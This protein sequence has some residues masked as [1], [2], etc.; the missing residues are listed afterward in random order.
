MEA[1]EGLRVALI[2]YIYIVYIQMLLLY[3]FICALSEESN[4]TAP[5]GG[6]VTQ[7]TVKT[8]IVRGPGWYHLKR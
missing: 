5:F 7:T 2:P 3:E 1:G 6:L 8:V 4:G